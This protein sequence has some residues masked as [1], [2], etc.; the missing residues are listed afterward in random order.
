KDGALDST[1]L[2]A[3]LADPGGRIELDV[4]L[5]KSS[6]QKP[7][8]AIRRGQPSA[9]EAAIALRPGAD[10]EP[11]LQIGQIPIEL[12]AAES[13]GRPVSRSGRHLAEFKR[14]DRDNNKYLEESEI[15]FT[16][17]GIGFVEFAAMDRDGN[18]MVFEDEW[19]AFMEL[20]DA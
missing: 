14:A 13:R 2:E 17:Q 11:V 1:E 7:T 18:R 15:R 20:R 16:G 10:G 5:A 19:L 9:D 3:W 12:R 4:F 6:L 8:I